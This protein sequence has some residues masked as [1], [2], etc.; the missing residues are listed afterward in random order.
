MINV[1]I[2]VIFDDAGRDIYIVDNKYM[3]YE[4]YCVYKTLYKLRAR[5]KT[6]NLLG[7]YETPYID[8]Y[9][10][11]YEEE[12]KKRLDN[13]GCMVGTFVF[14]DSKIYSDKECVESFSQ[15]LS[16]FE[17]ESCHMVLL[18]KLG[19]NLGED[20]LD[21]DYKTLPRG[22][23][24][25]DNINNCFKVFMDPKIVGEKEYTDLVFKEFNIEDKVNIL[26]ADEE[27]LSIENVRI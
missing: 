20:V 21:L 25:Y 1:D 5:K 17:V 11:M 27:Y 4:I 14:I 7:K 9:L 12:V 3:T 15:D 19:Y 24:L 8:E 16:F 26:Y 23:V 2:K 22:Y 10:I 13:K 6:A 18:Q